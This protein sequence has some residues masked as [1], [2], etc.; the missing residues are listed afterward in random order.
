MVDGTLVVGVETDEFVTVGI[1]PYPQLDGRRR[2]ANPMGITHQE[3]FL[4]QPLSVG[5]MY[6]PVSVQRTTGGHGGHGDAECAAADTG[7]VGVAPP[8][9]ALVAGAIG[10]NG[11]R[12]R[13]A[14]GRADSGG[15]P[16]TA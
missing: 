3:Y 12:G 15:Q 9:A 14:A 5:P 7:V 1:V 10:A 11:G 13:P 6:S 4:H 2:I 16:A 8:A